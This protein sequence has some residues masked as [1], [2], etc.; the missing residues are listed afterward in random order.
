MATD[1]ACSHLCGSVESELRDLNIQA[2]KISRT[3]QLK[4]LEVDELKET[5]KV[6]ETYI[7]QLEQQVR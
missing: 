1:M 4:E 5:Q 2:G 3:I 7:T 6:I